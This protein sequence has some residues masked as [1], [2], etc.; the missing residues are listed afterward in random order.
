M[1]KKNVF[2]TCPGC[3]NA[4]KTRDDFLSDRSLVL[5]GYKA[6]FKD[7]EYGMFFFTHNDE[8]CHSTMTLMVEDFKNLYSG[9]IYS[10]NKALSE[11]CPRYCIDEK[12]LS[13]CDALCECAFAREITQVI[14]DNQKNNIQLPGA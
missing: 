7:L 1:S 11:E 9:P 3:F 4:W 14:V 6:D 5:N 8:S 12:Q 13:R 2:K 10:E